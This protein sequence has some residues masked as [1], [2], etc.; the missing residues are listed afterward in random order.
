VNALYESV[1]GQVDYLDERGQPVGAGAVVPE[2]AA[3]IRRWA[4]RPLTGAPDDTV[5]IQVLV[6][7]LANGKRATGASATGQGPGESLITTARTRM[8]R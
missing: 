1:D 5:V 8:R 7:P 3:Y 4:V 6:V 2:S